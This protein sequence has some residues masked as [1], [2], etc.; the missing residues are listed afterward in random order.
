MVRGNG[1]VG[2]QGLEVQS[3]AVSDLDSRVG[4][5]SSLRVGKKP[6][7]EKKQKKQEEVI[8]SSLGVQTRWEV[9][10]LVEPYQYNS[11]AGPTARY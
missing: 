3:H 11:S 8:A 4:E 1:H 7:T 2:T 9:E 6:K 10:R 5:V